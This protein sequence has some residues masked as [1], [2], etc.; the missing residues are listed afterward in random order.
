[1]SVRTRRPGGTAMSVRTRRPGAS[2]V[3]ASV[4]D[5]GGPEAMGD[6][7]SAGATARHRVRRAR[8]LVV[9]AA[10]L[11]VIVLITLLSGTGE[12]GAPL[13]PENPGP[14]GARGVA[15]VLADEGVDVQRPGS[16]DE[17]L[18]LL[19]AGPATLFLNDARQYLSA[20]QVATLT[21]A[22]DR[23]V[24]A[25]PGARQLTALE[26][27]I[28]LV[29]PLPFDP[30]ND[31]PPPEAAC[32][33]SR[34]SAAGTITATGSL[35]SGPVECFPSAAD[36]GTGGLYVTSTE[37]SV[38]VLGAPAVLANR[39]ITADGNAALALQLLGF[40]PALVWFEP[41]G[42]DVVAVGEGID[43]LT[44]LPPWVDVLLVWLLV[45]AVLAMLWR[46]RR[47][48]P[49]ATEPLPV[50]V[51]A[52]ETAEGRARLYQDAR[53]VEHAAATLRSGTLTRLARRLRVDRSAPASEII[54]AAAHRSGRPRDELEARLLHSPTTNRE[55]VP[56]SQGLLDLEKEIT[57]P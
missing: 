49:L 36:D 53:S 37:G 51:R 27:D 21:A 8:P 22:A 24:L 39:S 10:A 43:P 52:A 17:A 57:P 47:M 14:E 1:M 32:T 35:Y 19:D 48:G 29:G 33:D 56:W 11:A 13:S 55:L 15:Q 18:A 54:A 25:T 44:L 7:G 26:E 45:C 30:G 16:F 5:A 2:A 46:G 9:G 23:S 6:G 38:G 41:T 12:E 4:D 34:A 20:T 50:L 40:S 28:E 31:T 3:A 42:A